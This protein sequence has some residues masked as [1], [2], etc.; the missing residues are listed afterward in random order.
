MPGFRVDRGTAL[1]FGASS[2]GD[3]INFSLFARH[4]TGVTL[5]L[6]A[7]GDPEPALELPLDD[8]KNRT[9]DVWHVYIERVV[10]GVEYCFRVERNGI[11]STEL[12]DPYAAMICRDTPWGVQGSS[13]RCGTAV[14]CFDWKYD[15]PLNR[16]LAETIIYELHV[17]GF[18]IHPSSLCTRPGTFDALTEMIPYLRD[19]GVTAVELLPVHEFNECEP[20]RTN[21]WGYQPLAFFAPNSA[22]ASP[23][24]NAEPVFEFKAMVQSFHSAGIEVILDVVFNHTGEG[25]R[26]APPVSFRGI[27]DA[28]YYMIDP[29]TGEYLDYTGCG[30]TL[31][32]NHPAVRELILNCLR[33]WV[34]EMHVD[35]FRFDLAAV[36]G[37]G[38][39]GAVLSSPPLLDVLARDPILSQTKLIAEAW[40]AAGLYQVGSFGSWSRWAEWNGKYRDDVRR[41]V[42]GDDGM[43]GAL[44]NRFAGSPDLFQTSAR[45]PYHSINF[46]TCHDG[47]TLADLVSYNVKHNETNGEGNHD[48]TDANWSW[49]CGVE[50]PTDDAAVVDLRNRQVRNLLALLLVSR[51]VPM[52]L[53]GDEFGRTQ[54]GNNNA[55]CQDNEVG[56]VDWTLAKSNADLLEFTRRLIR[57]RYLH[58]VL[59][60]GNFAGEEARIVWHGVKLNEPDWGWHSHSLAIEMAGGGDRVY[61]IAN[62]WSGSLRFQLPEGA[63]KVEFDTARPEAGIS[64]RD[65]YEVAGRSVV[66]LAGD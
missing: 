4:A 1:P 26:S 13:M 29:L 65:S 51:G 30:N 27:D 36:L 10:P 44:A 32:C 48:G 16:P 8:R 56:W 25:A 62:A 14:S 34:M 9:G 66:I 7:P 63:W 18:T 22:Y 61:V 19:L 35:G 24:R 41:F 55:Y 28:V 50:G 11:V 43:V 33:Y 58:P 53:A 15:Q 3:G 12:L 6:H 40:D 49:N 42:R 60:R 38:E 47:F 45:Q 39:D 31:N 17:R 57:F 64:A 59:R 46:I 2:A 20:G 23:K 37:R 54:R 5:V 21:L 52:L